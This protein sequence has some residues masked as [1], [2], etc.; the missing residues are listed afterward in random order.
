[1]EE[2]KDYVFM[3]Y[4]IQSK[5]FIK[6]QNVTKKE[7]EILRKQR[8]Y[9]LDMLQHW[10]VFHKSEYKKMVKESGFWN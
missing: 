8:V 1:M 7:A 3:V 2:K 4:D 6:N 10:L 9:A 5:R